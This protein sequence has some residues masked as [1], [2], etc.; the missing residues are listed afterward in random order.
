MHAIHQ[1]EDQNTNRSGRTRS[2]RSEVC[3]EPDRRRPAPSRRK[4]GLFSVRVSA[5]HEPDRDTAVLSVHGE[6]DLGTAPMLRAALLPVLEHQRGSIV[7]DL[8]DVPFMDSTGVHVLLDTVQRL[9]PENRRFAIACRENGPVHRVLAMVAL[10]DVVA[11]YR[12]RGSAVMGADDRLRSHLTGRR[13]GRSVG[14][15]ARPPD[16]R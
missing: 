4:S 9:E 13:V 15:R 10:L 14:I 11:V 16:P 8:S 2:G 5:A 12:S 3:R 7:V 1:F 6:I